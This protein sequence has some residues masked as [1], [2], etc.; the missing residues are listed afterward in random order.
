MVTWEDSRSPRIA[1]SSARNSRSAAVPVTLS[2]ATPGR[3]TTAACASAGRPR[4]A[5]RSAGET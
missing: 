5:C 4:T 1:R 2:I 3:N